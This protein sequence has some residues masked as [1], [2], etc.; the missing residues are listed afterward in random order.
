[1]KRIVSVLLTLMLLLSLAGCDVQTWFSER[2]YNFHNYDGVLPQ[3]IRVHSMEA[4]ER[5]VSAA[6]LSDEEFADFIKQARKSG[7]Q[8][9]IPH[10]T[11]KQQIKVF[12]WLMEECGIPVFE[13]GIEPEH[14]LLEYRP[15]STWMSVTYHLKGIKY[16]FVSRPYSWEEH[17][18]RDYRKHYAFSKEY[19]EFIFVGGDTAYLKWVGGSLTGEM[20]Q[21][22][23]HDGARLVYV[24][25]TPGVDLQTDFRWD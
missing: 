22:D 21:G 7:S 13:D 17:F 25:L 3:T 23:F 10:N 12:A 19:D 4:L 16:R 11:Q 5:L 15:E 18:P 1:M 8:L 6:Q 2:F 20:I 24:I 9:S 14:F